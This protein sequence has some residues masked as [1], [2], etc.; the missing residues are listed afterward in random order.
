MA[1]S[2]PVEDDAGDDEHC[3]HRRHLRE[4]LRGRP[5]GGFL[6]GNSLDLGK[7][8]RCVAGTRDGLLILLGT[9]RDEHSLVESPLSEYRPCQV[10]T[11]RRRHF[12]SRAAGLCARGGDLRA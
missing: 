10:R 4:R 6:H 8:H 9:P 3:R 11:A 12:G 2:P 1:V 7:A 5:F